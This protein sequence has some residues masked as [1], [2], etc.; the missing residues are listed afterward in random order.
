MCFLNK[1]ERDLIEWKWI[2]NLNRAV[3]YELDWFIICIFPQIERIELS[4]YIFFQVDFNVLFYSNVNCFVCRRRVSFNYIYKNWREKSSESLI[5]QWLK[6]VN[7]KCNVINT[8]ILIGYIPPRKWTW[9]TKTHQKR[10]FSAFFC[11]VL[12][13]ENVKKKLIK[14]AKKK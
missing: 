10:K 12:E 4:L 8:Y 9:T 7:K 3:D 6:Q 14:E 11:V 2:G 5:L 1:T 13:N